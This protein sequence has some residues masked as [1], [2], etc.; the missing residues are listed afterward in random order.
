MSETIYL[1]CYCCGSSEGAVSDERGYFYDGQPLICGC[2][3]H[4]SLDSESDPD[5]VTDDDCP[6]D[7]EDT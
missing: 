6:C 2:D 7:R 1:P 3:G 5:V 4:V